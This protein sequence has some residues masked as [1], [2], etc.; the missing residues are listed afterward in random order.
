MDTRK[1]AIKGSKVSLELVDAVVA[2]SGKDGEDSLK[3]STQVLTNAKTLK[4]I[5][6]R[7]VQYDLSDV[8]TIPIRIDGRTDMT[9]EGYNARWDHS[10]RISMH[11][12]HAKIKKADLL[13]WQEDINMFMN[14]TSIDSSNW[15]SA[16]YKNFL[17]KEVIDR[18]ND[19]ESSLPSI[20]QVV[21]QKHT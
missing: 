12:D 1:E 3:V 20:T 7:M 8:G 6:A 2:K 18:V 15:I 17:S 10:R 16:L 14:E 4:S 11:S 13:Q 5:Y 21:L 19:E 9:V